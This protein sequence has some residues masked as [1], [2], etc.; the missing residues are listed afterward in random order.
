MV[1][2]W[3]GH[4]CAIYFSSEVEILFGALDFMKQLQAGDRKRQV[5]MQ[6]GLLESKAQ[7]TT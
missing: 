4:G 7:V 6:L 1:T 3:V 2:T 5:A